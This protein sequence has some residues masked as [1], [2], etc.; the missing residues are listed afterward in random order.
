VQRQIQR[1][2]RSVM[3]R[4]IVVERRV[5]CAKVQARYPSVMKTPILG[6][7]VA[8]SDHASSEELLHLVGF[9]YA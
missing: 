5:I 7:L 6:R 1:N 2:A 4:A 9:G 8:D 3:A